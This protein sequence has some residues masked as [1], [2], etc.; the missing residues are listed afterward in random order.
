MSQLLPQQC[1]TAKPSNR[2]AYLTWGAWHSTLRQLAPAPADS[3]LATSP[4]RAVL[5]HDMA[6]AAW[7]VLQ[8]QGQGRRVFSVALLASRLQ[9]RLNPASTCNRV[10]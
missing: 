6:D 3:S 2:R 1:R 9:C 5:C 10:T 4:C 7:P 8:R